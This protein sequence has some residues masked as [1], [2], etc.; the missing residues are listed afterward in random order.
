MEGKLK[1]NLPKSPY[2]KLTDYYIGVG[3]LHKIVLERQLN[4]TGVYRG[5]HQL[6]MYI[7]DNPNASQKEIAR[8]NQ[9]SAATVAVSLKKLELGGYIRRAVDASDNRC[10]Q[11]CLTEKGES[12][13]K[14]SVS[15]FLN[16]QKKMY[17]GFTQEELDNLQQYLCRIQDNL[18]KNLSEEE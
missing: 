11:I 12:V 9:I 16:I 13:V 5:Q 1:L 15:I 3:R 2:R 8:L 10:N 4:K 7:A 6:L 18:K 17:E 14:K